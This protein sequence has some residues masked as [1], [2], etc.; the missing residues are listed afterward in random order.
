MCASGVEDRRGA[1]ADAGIDRGEASILADEIDVDR[2][3]VRETGELDEVFA[4]AA[5][6]QGTSRLQMR[7]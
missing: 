5:T 3:P 6:L 2:E 7:R 1:A 4:V